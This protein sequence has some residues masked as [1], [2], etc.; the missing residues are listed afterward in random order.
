[1]WK[2]LCNWV[3]S[4]GWTRFE[5]RARNVKSDSG[6]VSGGNEEHVTG[7]WRK[8]NPRYK[9]AKNLAEL[10]S[11]VLWKAKLASDKTGF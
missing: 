5:A 3:M 8:G 11:S 2:Q 10:C 9:V 7:N 4:R 1:M 6:E